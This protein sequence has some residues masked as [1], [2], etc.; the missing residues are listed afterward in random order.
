[1]PYRQK[2]SPKI[3]PIDRLSNYLHDRIDIR[4]IAKKW[5]NKVN[6]SN[7]KIDL[8]CGMRDCFSSRLPGLF[9]AFINHV[10]TGLI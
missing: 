1:L 4:Y 2:I 8:L 3:A 6:Y 9:P 5:I 7:I 10:S